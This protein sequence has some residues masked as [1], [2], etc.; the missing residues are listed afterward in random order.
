M[1]SQNLEQHL[2]AHGLRPTRQ[3]LAIAHLLFDGPDRHITAEQLHR[4]L[5]QTGSATSLATVYNTLNQLLAR[6]LIREVSVAPGVAYFD[7]NTDPHIHV[8]H[9]QSGQISDADPEQ[10]GINLDDLRL[11]EGTTLSRIDIVL[12]VRNAEP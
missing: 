10:L 9:E 1:D 11:P 5:A 6:N 4:E 12:R 8:Y 3:R 7:T 2:I